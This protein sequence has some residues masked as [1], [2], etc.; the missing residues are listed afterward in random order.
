MCDNLLVNGYFQL[1][2]VYTVHLV[3]V[4]MSN[5]VTQSHYVSV[6]FLLVCAFSLHFVA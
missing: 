5:D 2:Q 3:P 1:W 4:V 6:L